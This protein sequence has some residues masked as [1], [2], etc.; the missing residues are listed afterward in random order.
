MRTAYV[1]LAAFALAPGFAYADE[2]TR[3]SVIPQ[4]AR[5]LAERGRALHDAG[6]YGNAIIAFKEAYVIAPS[7]GLLFNLAQAYRLQGNC[8][9]AAL[10]Y[11]RYLDTAPSRDGRALAVGHL[12]TV[13]RCAHDQGVAIEPTGRAPP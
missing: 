1:T 4:K 8:D 3:P 2:P 7:S 13:E 11:R 5:L 6:D 9:D 10:M 12:V